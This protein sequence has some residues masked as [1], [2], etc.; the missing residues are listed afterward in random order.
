MLKT[1]YSTAEIIVAILG[2]LSLYP[3]AQFIGWGSVFIA[4]AIIL[5]GV[6]ILYLLWM[7]KIREIIE[8]TMKKRINAPGAYRNEELAT[9]YEHTSFWFFVLLAVL[10]LVIVPS[11]LLTFF[12]F[13]S[14][15]MAGIAIIVIAFIC[16]VM[17]VVFPWPSWM[18]KT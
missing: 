2:V 13:D 4:G 17:L 18:T 14:V 3:L 9:R 16:T 8:R 6:L 12:G 15:F 10:L 5:F 1:H 7:L 11:F